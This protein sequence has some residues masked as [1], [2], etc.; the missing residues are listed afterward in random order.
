MPWIDDVPAVVLA[1]FG[2]QEQGGAVA[3]VLLG[4]VSPSGKIPNPNPIS[5][6]NPNLSFR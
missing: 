3:D 1:W 6:S 2:G 4:D 5:N